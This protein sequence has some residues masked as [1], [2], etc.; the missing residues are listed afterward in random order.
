ML[1]LYYVFL[2]FPNSA[3]VVLFSQTNNIY[4]SLCSVG[5]NSS[6]PDPCLMG[7]TP[8]QDSVVEYVV[9]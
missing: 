4:C 2:I 9:E 3:T 8:K 6:L 1:T 5:C 7:F